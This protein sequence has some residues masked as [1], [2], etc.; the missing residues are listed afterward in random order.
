[1]PP[2]DDGPPTF[3]LTA[4]GPLAAFWEEGECPACCHLFP[5]GDPTCDLYCMACSGTG[6][7]SRPAPAFAALARQ[8]PNL[9]VVVTDR[10]P[11][12]YPV[13]PHAYGWTTGVGHADK[14]WHL[15]VPVLTALAGGLTFGVW[16]DYHSPA[17]AH[18]ALGGAL[19]ALGR[20]KEGS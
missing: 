6:R 5:P 8:R 7:V 10:T 12:F 19:L 17:A 11:Q 18:S 16:R 9:E 3:T 14:S 4:E 15:P 13:H 2:P 1:M 20:G